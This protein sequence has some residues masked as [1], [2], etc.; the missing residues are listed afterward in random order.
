M[1]TWRLLLLSTALA[2]APAAANAQADDGA[3]GVAQVASEA[4]GASL[5]CRGTAL[6]IMAAEVS[7][8]RFVCQINGA[9]AGDSSFAVQA[10]STADQTHTAVPV[11]SGTLAS[12]A[13]A[14]SGAF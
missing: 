10:I 5:D 3:D 14:C 12:G 1:S 9:P 2:L 7:G 6:R 4:P 8:A 11:C 13:G